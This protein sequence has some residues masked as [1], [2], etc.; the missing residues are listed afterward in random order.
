MCEV[1][2]SAVTAGADTVN[3]DQGQGYSE[4]FGHMGIDC[5]SAYVGSH[6]QSTLI[7]Y[8]CCCM[9]ISSK[10]STVPEYLIRT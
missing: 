6:G 8:P 3:F 1:V 2:W 10:V 4:H 7:I 9:R 5:L